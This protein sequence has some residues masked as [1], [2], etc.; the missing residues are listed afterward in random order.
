MS[1]APETAPFHEVVATAAAFSWHA[2]FEPFRRELPASAA[3]WLTFGHVADDATAKKIVSGWESADRD[4]E[5]LRYGFGPR[6]EPRGGQFVHSTI[7][8]A[9]YYDLAVAGLAGVAVSI[10]SRHRLAVENRL[11]AG[12]A[13]RLGGHYALELL[14]PAEFTWDDVPDLRKHRALQDYRAV[15]REIEAEALCGELSTAEID[16][17]IHREYEGR[18]ERAASKGIP[19]G[20]RLALQ[21]VGFILG[22]AADSAAP[23]VGG[24]AATGATFAVGEALTHV[25]R[26][27]W[28]TVDR[29]LRGRR[30]GL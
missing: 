21:A 27:R 15:L 2:T 9:G 6:P 10:D 1:D 4:R 5:L 30:N 22:A 24:A 25:A 8:E 14:L 16:D 11:R 13:H 12:D 7:L 19:L 23:L 20:G 17:R 29:R 3:R 18:I 28:L 26:P